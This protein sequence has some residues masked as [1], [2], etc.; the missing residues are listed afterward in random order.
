MHFECCCIHIHCRSLI[1]RTVLLLFSPHQKKLKLLSQCIANLVF[2]LSYITH[3]LPLQFLPGKYESCD[4]RMCVSTDLFSSHMYIY[5]NDT[6]FTLLLLFVKNLQ[7]FIFLK[8]EK[9]K[10]CCCFFFSQFTYLLKCFQRQYIMYKKFYWNFF[11]T[12]ISDYILQRDASIV[13]IVVC[14]E[15]GFVNTVVIHHIGS[16]S[17]VVYCLR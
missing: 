2:I 5:L 14:S 3:S 6:C 7:N 10:I 1:Q 11:L 15:I 16:V 9:L 4:E 13:L 8:V 17:T 12:N